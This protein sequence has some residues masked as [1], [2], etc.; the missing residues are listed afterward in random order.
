MPKRQLLLWVLCCLPGTA[1]ANCDEHLTVEAWADD[2]GRIAG[3]EASVAA[4]PHDYDEYRVGVSYFAYDDLYEGVSGSARL[5]AGDVLSVFAG[6]GLLV[7]KA[8]E[9]ADDDG[10]DNDGD[11]T[12]DESGEE[13]IHDL[14][15]FV[16]PEVG[17]ALHAAG[18]GLTV[19]AR[20]FY[21]EEFSGDVIY[22]VGISMGFGGD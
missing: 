14:T 8:E 16:Y 2:S 4:C 22:S 19:S 20:R 11:G 7:G 5:R 18:V 3:L 9:E 13:E 10:V 15:A 21:G 6:A 1:L 17:L 12:V